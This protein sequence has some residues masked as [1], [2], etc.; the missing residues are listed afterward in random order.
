MQYPT[1]NAFVEAAE[2][3]DDDKAVACFRALIGLVS[4]VSDLQTFAVQMRA[5]IRDSSVLED[6]AV[7]M[8]ARCHIEMLD[9]VV[10]H[11][12]QFQGIDPTLLELVEGSY[13]A[14]SNAGRTDDCMRTLSLLFRYTEQAKSAVQ[15]LA[16]IA[17]LEIFV[18]EKSSESRGPLS[19][20][21]FRMWRMDWQATVIEDATNAQYFE[22]I[23][24]ARLDIFLAEAATES[25]QRAWNLLEGSLQLW[26][27]AAQS[28][29]PMRHWFASLAVE[30]FKLLPENRAEEILYAAYNAVDQFVRATAFPLVFRDKLTDGWSLMRGKPV[31]GW[32]LLGVQNPLSN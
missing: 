30:A 22:G 25:A 9:W 29:D 18:R 31:P 11:K 13:A 8:Q 3:G 20:E 24:T 21:R 23:A 10:S 7:L 5:A 1:I 6:R 4:E 16:V 15:Q 32:N 26:A 28:L 17:R 12:L 2:Q 14:F 19:R 27:K